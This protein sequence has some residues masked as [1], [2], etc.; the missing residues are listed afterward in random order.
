MSDI[1][2]CPHC[3]KYIDV[4]FASPMCTKCGGKLSVDEKGLSPEDERNISDFAP[5]PRLARFFATIIDLTIIGI[6]IALLSLIAEI[7][8]MRSLSTILI[9]ILSVLIICV[10]PPMAERYNSGATLGKVI[11]GLRVISID[12]FGPLSIRQVLGRHFLKLVLLSIFTLISVLLAG[13]PLLVALMFPDI[14][15]FHN[16]VFDCLVVYR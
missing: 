5:A 1:I 9:L 11:V 6:S 13:I 10:Y 15:S 8:A 16:K 2:Q 7:P 3:A 4:T 12:P 14:W